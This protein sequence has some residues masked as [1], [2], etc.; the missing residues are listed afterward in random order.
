MRQE[1]LYRLTYAD[2][3]SAGLPVNS[4]DPRTLK[5]YEQGQEI[6]IQVSGQDDGIFHPA[7][8]LLFYG[9]VPF[10]RYTDH[11]VY[12]LRYG[13]AP[14]LRMSSRP[15]TPGS[16][17]QG[18]AW[19]TT[20]YDENRYYDSRFAAPDGDH[21]YAEQLR[22]PDAPSRSAT[23]WLRP[24]DAVVP[25]ATLQIVMV[26]YT[27]NQ[28]FNPDHHARFA[29]NGSSVGGDGLWWDGY[30]AITVTITVPRSLLQSGLNTVTLTLP[31]DTGTMVEGMWLDSVSL[32]YA[33]GA[34][35][36]PPLRLTCQAGERK[37]QIGG[38]VGSDI[39]LYDISDPARPVQLTGATV[40]GGTLSFAD[41]PTQPVT[42]L[43]LTGTQIRRP[44]AIILDTPSNLHSPAHQADY[45]IIAHADLIAA[46]QP[47]AAFHQAQGRQV[48]VVDVQQIYDE[49]NGGL[50]A[51]SA[52]REFL[53]YAY[54][55]WASPAPTYVLL[56]GDGSYDPLDHA[57]Y[58][59]P[60]LIPPYLAM[61]DP[62]WGE[63]AADPLYVA[64]SGND[65]LPD[66]LLGRLPVNTAAE[67]RVVAAK[68]IQYQQSP[69]LGD[70]NAHHVF[71]ADN[72]DAAG[73]FAQSANAIYNAFIQ[74]PWIGSKIYLDTLSI[75]A[76]RQAVLSAWQS[77]ALLISFTG[78]SSWHQWAAESIFDIHTVAQLRNEQ[79]LPVLLSMTC[80]TGL[81]Q[82]P[83]YGTLDESLLRQANGGAVATWSPS[84]LGIANGHDELHYG[85]Y[86]AV[87]NHQV[88]ELGAA[89]QSAQ[90][91][92]YSQPAD[93][94]NLLYTYHLFGDPAM[95]LNLTIR[96]WP[97]SIYLPLARKT[98]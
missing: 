34:V 98:S 7:D 48:T 65:P 15:V 81:F 80:F 9:R 22:L 77:G 64:I 75:E 30:G 44:D 3:Q 83:E 35:G 28:A 95:S 18:I 53:T 31:G 51:P 26:G 25:T 73:N 12:W 29:L 14:G 5:L 86:R 56:V 91:Y 11:N 78:H 47:L 37:Y 66:M 87:F 19:A 39:W 42:Y 24:T 93:H 71:V 27:Q 96:P 90:L 4:L 20:I 2:L 72:A 69:Y 16:Q 58:H 76:A 70:W 82:H 40:N 59:A 50:L 61:V 60:T 84:G 89:I 8:S 52:I 1:G 63:T 10:S 74:E 67:A 36:E 13:D 46:V 41:A 57:G 54:E 88:T 49:F 21:W 92:L 17:N 6:A 43:A 23:L 97:F 38:F 68:I 32:T 85:L 94:T 79:R 62:W 33:V 55:N 45:V